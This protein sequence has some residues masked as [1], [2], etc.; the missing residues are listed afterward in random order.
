MLGTASTGS[1]KFR[2]AGITAGVDIVLLA[3]A[4]WQ[5]AA[6]SGSRSVPGQAP[7]VRAERD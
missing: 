3:L 1:G 2:A 7:V 4:A 6:V 5:G